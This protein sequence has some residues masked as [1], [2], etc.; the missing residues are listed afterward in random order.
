MNLQQEI[1]ARGILKQATDD[2]FFE[3]YEKGGQTLYY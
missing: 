2:S 3:L 1:E